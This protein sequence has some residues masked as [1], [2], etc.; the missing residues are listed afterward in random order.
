MTQ[1]APD[2]S[3][4]ID[5]EG[6]P[7]DP[8]DSSQS[9]NR[10]TNLFAHGA[11]T[12]ITLRLRYIS[13]F[14]WAIDHLSE[15]DEDDK[16]RYR[17]LKN[18]EKLFG[19]SSRY[20][21]LKH[22]QPSALTGMD[23]NT[24]FNY[25]D[26]E[27]DAVDLDE[28]E[29]LKNDSY[30]YQRFYENLLQKLLLKRGDFTL[31]EAGKELADIVG[32]R[33]GEREEHILSCA[34]TGT[35]TRD[36][37]ET[38]SHDF[39]NQSVYYDE[40]FEDERKALQKIFLGFF[41]WDGD[42]QTGSVHLRESI[43]EDISLAVR[44]HLKTTLERGDIE[45]VNAAKLYKKYHRGYHN[46]R[47]AF[48]LFLLRS[49]QLQTESDADP[50]TLTDSD[51][52]FDQFRSL[53]HIYWQQVYLGYALD[54]QLEAV[55]TFL[56]SRIPARYDYEQLINAAGDP[57]RIQAEVNGILEGLDVTEGTDDTSASQ[58]TRNLM[59][60]GTTSRTQPSVSIT[61]SPPNFQIDLGTVQEAVKAW[62]TDG[63][64]TVPAL[65]GVEE[66]N[67][68]LLAKAVRNSLNDL[69]ANIDDEE[70]Q[71]AAWS[72]A[73]G[74]STVLVLLEQ[75]RLKHQRNEREWLYN[76]AYSR[77]DSKFASL[78][79]LDRFI[80]GLD[81]GTPIDEVARLLLKKQVVGTHLRVFYDRLSPGNLKRIL[82]FDQD[83]RLCLE[84]QKERGVRPFRA[85]PSLVRFKE[86]NMLLRDC[87]L[88]KD[89][90]D[91]DFLVTETGAELL[92]RA[93]GGDQP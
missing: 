64:E 25:D 73:L 62:T 21:E 52:K 77:L 46:Y 74:R 15:L 90:P 38:F 32:T 89:D 72:R 2:W 70:E 87:G 20:E 10:I 66:A 9:R 81:P 13:I 71:L 11:I 45:D 31:T 54:S 53:M 33:L 47:R 84:T 86:M 36:D 68:V 82:S 67:E 57:H 79:A 75:S 85:R 29:L 41:E 23:G 56:N 49:R 12:S 37:F 58:L 88:L 16:E 69:H 80:S 48:S 60:Y 65:P 26:E 42:K 76:Y 63:W 59:L 34:E 22:D 92:R 78:P 14:S 7:V 93:H 83:N 51:T 6:T 61:P 27:F 44:D 5:E 4:K 19:L 30:A 40:A 35:A 8:L 3:E 24:E 28:L 1:L 50:I 55:T 43:P 18:I 39:A 17:Q 91:A